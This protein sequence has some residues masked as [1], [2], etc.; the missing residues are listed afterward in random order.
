MVGEYLFSECSAIEKKQYLTQEINVSHQQIQIQPQPEP[1]TQQQK[2]IDNLS[3][4]NAVPQMDC[5]AN[6]DNNSTST[7]SETND[8][9]NLKASLE[10][11]GK[12][13]SL[14]LCI[15]ILYTILCTNFCISRLKFQ[16]VYQNKPVS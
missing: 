13:L 2:S 4:M 9:K 8:G 3:N 12:L 6:N 5:G 11:N 10:Q 16:K 1:N 15:K 7:H 14:L